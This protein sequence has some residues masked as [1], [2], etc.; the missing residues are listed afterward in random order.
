MTTK[1]NK[2]TPK[3]IKP[4]I[5]SVK[6]EIKSV[7]KLD[8]YKKWFNGLKHFFTVKPSPPQNKK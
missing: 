4:F 3:T 6:D 1:G 8:V 5:V 2:P 7:D